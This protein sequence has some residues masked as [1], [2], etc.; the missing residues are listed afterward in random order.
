MKQ[1][2]L[3]TDT[4][5]SINQQINQLQNQHTADLEKL[6]K[7]HAEQYLDEALDRYFQYDDQL[8]TPSSQQ[9]SSRS[10]PNDPSTK[11]DRIYRASRRI[12][13]TSFENEVSQMRS[14]HLKALAPLLQRKAELEA[15][16]Q[17]AR[18]KKDAMFPQSVEEYRRIWNKDVQVRVA[19]FLTSN[20]PQQLKMLD[21]YNWAWSQVQPLI[22]AFKSDAGFKAEIEKRARD[23]EV[24]DPRRKHSA[25]QL[26]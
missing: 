26:G 9:S 12:T 14:A 17:L 3:P 8:A 7:H 21:E 16:D 23:V 5:G 1:S 10:N 22:N 24:V 19:R 4:L 18:R 6:N 13:N 11:L 25:M 2:E 20:Q 15:Q